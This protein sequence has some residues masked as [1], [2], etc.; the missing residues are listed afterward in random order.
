[1][2]QIEW[3]DFG[4]TEPKRPIDMDWFRPNIIEKAMFAFE[5]V[6]KNASQV[7][8]SPLGGID[9]HGLVFQLTESTEIVETEN[10]ISV[11]MRINHSVN[12]S[13]RLAQT[14]LAKIRRRIHLNDHLRRSHLDCAAQTFVSWIN[15]GTHVALAA[16][17][18]DSV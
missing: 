18:W 16:D 2:G 13:D 7:V 3:D 11:R 12:S 5:G 10:M 15:R 9:R 6:L 17:H 4:L 8:E 14:L 1:V